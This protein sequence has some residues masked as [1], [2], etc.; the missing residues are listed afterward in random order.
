[1]VRNIPTLCTALFLLASVS[2]CGAAPLQG[3][4]APDFSVRTA[5]GQQLSLSTLKGSVII[6]DFFA[7]WCAPCRSA[8]AH[9]VDLQRRYGGRG[10]C[11][12]GLDTDDTSE[13]KLKQ[14]IADKGVNYPVATAP[15]AMQ[16][17][18]AVRALP[19]LLVIAK[20]GRIAGQFTGFNREIAADIDRLVA[21]LLTER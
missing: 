8:T 16:L 11:I 12:I 14:F 1:M 6:L 4:R 17:Q 9:L 10:V 15:E 20:N 3:E 19:Q 7:P 5:S 2:I 13:K 21:T 18:Y